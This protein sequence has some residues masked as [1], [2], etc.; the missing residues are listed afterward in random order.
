MNTQF[1]K[2]NKKKKSQ[3]T[4]FFILVDLKF[5]F[6]KSYG[7]FKV[8]FKEILRFGQHLHKVR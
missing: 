2:G 4:K 5:I 8:S 7:I 3:I 6:T 1:A